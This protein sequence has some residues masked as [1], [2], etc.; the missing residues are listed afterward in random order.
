MIKME[1]RYTNGDIVAEHGHYYKSDKIVYQK[2]QWK[3]NYSC[4]LKGEYERLTPKNI[5]RYKIEVVGNIY[6]NS[7]LLGGNNG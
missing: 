6:E 7:E 2:I 5:E 4:W 1:K 3:E